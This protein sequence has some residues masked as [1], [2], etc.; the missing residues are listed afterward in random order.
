MPRNETIVAVTTIALSLAALGLCVAGHVG[1][2][3]ELCRVGTWTV[4]AALCAALSPL[5]LVL[6]VLCWR[7]V[8]RNR[9]REDPRWA[10]RDPARI[11]VPLTFA[12]VLGE[13]GPYV[14]RAPNAVTVVLGA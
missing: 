12:A 5:L 13:S 14:D 6:I 10:C 1:E 9:D 3:P 7:R 4:V 8:V 11:G 2:R